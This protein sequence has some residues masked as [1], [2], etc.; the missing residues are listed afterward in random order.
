MAVIEYVGPHVDG[1]VVPYGLGEIA[2]PHGVPIEVPDDLAAGLLDQ[3]SNWRA[4]KAA[5]KSRAA[6][7]HKEE[8]IGDE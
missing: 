3:P 4:T 1:V 8:V 2:A 6:D 5:A 7:G